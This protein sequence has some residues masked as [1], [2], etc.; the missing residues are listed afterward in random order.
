[1]KKFHL[2]WDSSVPKAVYI[3]L[4]KL[5]QKGALKNSPTR[6]VSQWCHRRNITEPFSELF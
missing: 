5:L 4:Q 1:M 2:F 6:G 3:I